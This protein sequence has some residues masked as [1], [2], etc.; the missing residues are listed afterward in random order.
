[1]ITIRIFFAPLLLEF[2]KEAITST[3]TRI[4]ATARRAPT[5]KSPSKTS[6]VA[7]G[8]AIPRIAPMI[9]PIKIL[10]IRLKLFH[11]CNRFFILKFPS[12]LI[13]IFS[14]RFM[15]YFLENKES[16]LSIICAFYSG[17]N[18]KCLFY[19]NKCLYDTDTQRIFSQ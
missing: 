18:R 17:V 3:N 16:I 4:R 10:T 15:S 5:N 7:F 8:A 14:R 19:K 11:F 13:F 6:P 2:A 12:F 1:M 9:R